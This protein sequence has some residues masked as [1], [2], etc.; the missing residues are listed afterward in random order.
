MVCVSWLFR[1]FVIGL[2]LQYS[3]VVCVH[4][5]Y[6]MYVRTFF[7]MTVMHTTALSFYIVYFKYLYAHNGSI[8]SPPFLLNTSLYTTALYSFFILFNTS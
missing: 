8:L 5:L 2:M 6:C 1:H 7:F 3:E 4:W